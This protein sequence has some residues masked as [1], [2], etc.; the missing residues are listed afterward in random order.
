MH[1]SHILISRRS[2]EQALGAKLRLSPLPKLFSQL[3]VSRMVTWCPDLCI[4]HDVGTRIRLFE[5]AAGDSKERGPGALL[6]LI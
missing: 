5:V 6:L 1:L 3:R 2:S 4:W